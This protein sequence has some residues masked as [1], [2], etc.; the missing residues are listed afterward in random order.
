MLRL[1]RTQ[2]WAKPRRKVLLLFQLSLIF[3]LSAAI[4]LQF[5]GDTSSAFHDVK[6]V[7]FYVKTC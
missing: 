4:F 7:S 6:N 1:S 3:S 2:K 5:T